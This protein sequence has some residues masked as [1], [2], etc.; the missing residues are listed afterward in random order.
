MSAE[1]L[2]DF[3]THVAT[4]DLPNLNSVEI[5]KYLNVVLLR[6]RLPLFRN[7][8]IRLCLK[9]FVI[10][11]NEYNTFDIFE[12]KRQRACRRSTLRELLTYTFERLHRIVEPNERLGIWLRQFYVDLNLERICAINANLRQFTAQRFNF[13]DSLDTLNPTSTLRV[14]IPSK[15]LPICCVNLKMG[16]G[17]IGVYAASHIYA[18]QQLSIP[19]TRG[20][21]VQ[22][23]KEWPNYSFDNGD[24]PDAVIHPDD[25]F[26]T[27]RK[28]CATIPHIELR[29]QHH[30]KFM[31]NQSNGDL[32]LGEQNFTFY[33]G[34]RLG[35][36]SPSDPDDPMSNSISFVCI[37]DVPTGSQ[38]LIN[39]GWASRGGI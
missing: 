2:A 10:P 27:W 19:I 39:Y 13:D 33:R 32:A 1:I 24:D 21:V 38:C 20:E 29:D 22:H 28:T 18:G 4:I 15:R 37:S 17:G 23:A 36:N 26:V 7:C 12:I 6:S 35:D 8:T 5:K 31:F 16:S 9:S 11:D 30:L 3:D 34:T 14:F 25:E